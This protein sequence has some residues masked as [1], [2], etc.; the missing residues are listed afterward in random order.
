MGACV[1]SPAVWAAAP[2][3]DRAME[4]LSSRILLRPSDP[5]R[6]RRFYRDILGLAVYREFGPPEDP[7]LSSSLARD[8]SRCPVHPT[9]NQPDRFG[10]G[11]RSATYGP[12]TNVSW[13]RE[14]RS[15]VNPGQSRGGWSRCG[16]RI[17]TA[18]VSCSSKSLPITRCGVTQGDLPA[19]RAP[20]GRYGYS[21][22]PP[23]ASGG[24]RPPVRSWSSSVWKVA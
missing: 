4:V 5:E 20:C 15:H 2:R 1:A 7:G 11:C 3:H 16:S 21:R 24:Y 14:R 6:S 23:T 9:T 17:R 13:R 22:R 19:V 8:C 10:S 12:S 18:Y